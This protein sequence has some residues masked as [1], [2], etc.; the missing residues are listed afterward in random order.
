M[1][2]STELDALDVPSRY[3]ALVDAYSN[4]A[5]LL[6]EALTAGRT[7]PTFANSCVILWLTRHATELFYKGAVMAATGILPQPPKP[8]GGH[9]LVFY[10]NS[11]RQHYPAHRFVFTPPASEALVGGGWS[12]EEVRQFLR[13]ANKVHERY[14]Y[15]TDSN[16]KDFDGVH[17]L[18][19]APL[20]ETLRQSRK[21]MTVIISQIQQER[22][23][24][25]HATAT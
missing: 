10:E 22:Q 18:D 15:P 16:G 5:V 6:C 13:D 23:G 11:F 2:V 24:G 25:Q 14:R 12:D 7:D 20:L 17:G 3:F 19:P 8:M 21:E 4:A 1:I 9:N